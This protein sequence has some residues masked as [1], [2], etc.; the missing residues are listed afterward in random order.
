MDLRSWTVLFALVLVAGPAAAQ[1]TQG[2]SSPSA[3]AMVVEIPSDNLY[4][5]PGC[6]LVAKAGSKVKV[7]RLGE[8]NR[9]GM[10]AHDCQGAAQGD[11][12]RS[13]AAAANAVP[14]YVQ[15][16]D[17]RYHLETCER[18]GKTPQ[19]Q[20][21]DKAGR[22]HFPCPVCKPPVRQRPGK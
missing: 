19:K 3:S 5:Q 21:L 10:K 2:S 11:D 16:G 6:P 8:A 7:M 18:L 14:V 1:D 17:R 4:H 12:G 9:R 15:E 13:R 22:T 20:P